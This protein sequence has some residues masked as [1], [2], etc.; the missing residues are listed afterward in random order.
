M[1]KFVGWLKHSALA[2]AAAAVATGVVADP[3]I[4]PPQYQHIV[5]GA[6]LM[7]L[8]VGGVNMTKPGTVSLPADHPATQI[9]AR[10]IANDKAWD[11][12]SG[13]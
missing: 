2:F 13:R 4:V 1:D 5:Y 9:A 11:P 6:I 8:Y 10:K 12:D 7:L 3:N